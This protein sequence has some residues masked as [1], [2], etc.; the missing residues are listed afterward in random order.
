MS[1]VT[2]PIVG[3]YVGMD[4]IHKGKLLRRIADQVSLIDLDEMQRQIYNS[5]AMTVL[6]KKWKKIS[7]EITQLQ[8]QKRLTKSKN[9]G[10]LEKLEK[11]RKARDLVR[12]EIYQKWKE[13]MEEL[14]EQ[15]CDRAS[16]PILFIGFNIY[17]KDYRVMV[18]LPMIRADRRWFFDI[19]PQTFASNQIKHN[20]QT[21]QDRIIKG[22]FPIDL[23]RLDYLAAK[24]TKFTSY[25]LRKKY[26]PLSKDRALDQI[27]KVL[28]EIAT[29][30]TLPEYLY[31]ASSIAHGDTIVP[32]KREPIIG[33]ASK[34]EAL[35]EIRSKV[36]PMSVVQLYQIASS[37]FQLVDGRCQ[38]LN[39]V[40]PVSVES[41]LITL[42]TTENSVA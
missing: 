27:N 35:A 4:D 38:S 2:V 40:F 23:I 34:D 9:T 29:A 15:A 28:A 10:L 11:K 39:P 16:K 41:I 21:Y 18:S 6:K 14:I 25:Y 12:D 32:R 8:R 33:Y 13:E 26:A 1:I 42:Q 19:V 30:A 24:Y 22:T 7:E 20:L 36:K 5:A 37:Q 3:H 31:Y 17:P